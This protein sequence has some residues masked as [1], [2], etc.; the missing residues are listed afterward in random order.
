MHQIVVTATNTDGEWLDLVIESN[1]TVDLVQ[2]VVYKADRDVPFYRLELIL[3]AADWNQKNLHACFMAIN[4]QYNAQKEFS[5]EQFI[6]RYDLN[7]ANCTFIVET[8]Q[9]DI[10]TYLIQGLGSKRL[11]PELLLETLKLEALVSDAVYG[12]M[13]YQRV[14]LEKKIDVRSVSGYDADSESEPDPFESI[15]GLFDGLE[16]SCYVSRSF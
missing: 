4:D 3:N 1:E 15:G 13:E 9:P 6:D 8:E 2:K 16:A 12:P 7:A 10:F 11:V 14:D 5:F